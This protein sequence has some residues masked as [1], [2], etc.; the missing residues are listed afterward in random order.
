MG[1]M[2]QPSTTY[3]VPVGTG[4][5]RWR[6]GYDFGQA[7]TFVWAQG[8][9]RLRPQRPRIQTASHS[10]QPPWKNPQPFGV[11]GVERSVFDSSPSPYAVRD[12]I[13]KL[14][15]QRRRIAKLEAQLSELAKA[16][17]VGA[18]LATRPVIRP[19]KEDL[20]VSRYDGFIFQARPASAH[21]PSGAAAV[22]A[23]V[24]AATAAAPSPAEALAPAPPPQ[25][26]PA[27]PRPSRIARPSTAGAVRV[28]S[29]HAAEIT[30]RG[31]GRV[32]PQSAAATAPQRPSLYEPVPP[33]P[34]VLT[35]LSGAGGP[36]TPHLTRFQR[37]QHQRLAMQDDTSPRLSDGRDT[38]YSA[39]YSR[40]HELRR[41]RSAALDVGY[42]PSAHNMASTIRPS[43]AS[44]A[45]VAAR[46]H[47]TPEPPT[48]RRAG[49]AVHCVAR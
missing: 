7:D 19:D 45:W 35:H 12:D 8:P 2:S 29:S 48:A 46:V 36:S 44:G 40:R 41:P 47:P 43:A 30:H 21:A 18:K 38:V 34:R 6:H 31:F 4:L 23:A 9:C 37:T 10:T 15:K 25:P 24:D 5:R 16:Q 39:S 49:M 13:I 1:S 20:H 3:I 14:R 26:P 22:D 32:R 17:H 33:D 11:M 42:H 28:C 27:Q